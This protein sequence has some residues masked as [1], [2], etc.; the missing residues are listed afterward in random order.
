MLGHGSGLNF[1]LSE[2]GTTDYPSDLRNPLNNE[3]VEGGYK[4][5]ETYNSVFGDFASSFEECRA[6][7]IAT[8]LSLHNEVLKYESLNYFN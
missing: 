3:L 2:D 5:G 1:L 4:P 6:E 7:T 8:F